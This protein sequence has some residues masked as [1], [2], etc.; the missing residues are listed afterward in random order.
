MIVTH[1]KEMSLTVFNLSSIPQ[2]VEMDLQ[3][4]KGSKLKEMTGQTFLKN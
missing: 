1:K 3:E 4:F 2:Q